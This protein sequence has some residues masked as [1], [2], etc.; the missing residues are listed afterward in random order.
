MKD[1][2]K[3]LWQN[4]K[5]VVDAEKLNNIED[6]VQSL[7]IGTGDINNRLQTV[8][9]TLP[10]KA[11]KD[12]THDNYANVMH[13]HN[14]FNDITESIEL[15]KTE[16]QEEFKKYFDNAEVEENILNLYSHGVLLKSL[17][18]PVGQAPSIKAI[19]GEFLCG[20][21]NCD[22]IVEGRAV[23]YDKTIWENGVTPVN[24][25][26]LNKIENKLFELV[27]A[28]N[29][30]EQNGG[31][32]TSTDCIHAG[33][34]APANKKGLWIDTAD[35][36][37]DSIDDPVLDQIRDSL[38]QQRLHIDELFYLVDGYLDDGLFED[39]SEDENILDGGIF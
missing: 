33:P 22:D 21:S 4:N 30:L 27:E 25:A 26:N 1:Y 14:E 17:E 28:I 7:T 35:E 8:E 12:H 29:N 2:D 9:D 31:T 10:M 39:S 38:K 36:S 16:L 37:T 18:L 19:C 20:E 23:S 32:G 3:T 5:T 13:T 11:A 15:L 6:Q 24:A 34:E